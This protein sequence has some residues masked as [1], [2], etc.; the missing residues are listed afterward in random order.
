MTRSQRRRRTAERYA[1]RTS[2]PLARPAIAAGI[3]LDENP[4][5]VKRGAARLAYME[6]FVT[7]LARDTSRAY[8]P[9]TVTTPARDSRGRR[10]PRMAPSSYTI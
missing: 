8:S 9:L 3:V 7:E 4:N 5:R 1:R 2:F 10:N 6:G